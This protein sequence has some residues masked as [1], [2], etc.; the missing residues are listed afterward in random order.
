MRLLVF[1]VAATSALLACEAPFYATT[2]G[3]TPEVA[4]EAG[5]AA[6]AGDGAAGTDAT[7][8]DSSAPD[9]GLPE[10][11]VPKADAPSE[12]AVSEAGPVDAGPLDPCP[13][14]VT[15]PGIE[16]GA[17]FCVPAPTEC[18]V[19]PSCLCVESYYV[20]SPGVYAGCVLEGGVPRL[21]CIEP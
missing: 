18:P 9:T 19:S 3:S 14:I 20:C 5:E 2:E 21:S 16:G 17:P 8:F 15:N 12:A 6:Q 4:A 7:V 10:T 13:V 11:G 1:W